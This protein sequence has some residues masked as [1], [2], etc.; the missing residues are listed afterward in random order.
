GNLHASD[1]CRSIHSNVHCVCMHIVY[2]IWFAVAVGL[3]VNCHCQW[4]ASGLQF[5]ADCQCI[6]IG[7][8][9][10][11]DCHC[12]WIASVLQLAMDCQWIVRPHMFL[13]RV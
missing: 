13:V 9:F 6:A 1:I 10:S 3:P 5:A 2:C 8:G 11:V 4:I 7:S 12:Q